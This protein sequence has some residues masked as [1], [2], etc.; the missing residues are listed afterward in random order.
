MKDLSV[1]KIRFPRREKHKKSKSQPL[2]R[3]Y[4]WNRK[5]ES[6]QNCAHIFPENK[7]PEEETLEELSPEVESPEKLSLEEK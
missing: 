2:K 1:L 3:L 6:I 7:P 5:Q 4:P